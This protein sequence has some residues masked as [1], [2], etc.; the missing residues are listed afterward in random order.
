M[1]YRSPSGG[2]DLPFMRFVVHRAIFGYSISS[3]GRFSF[4]KFLIESTLASDSSTSTNGTS[5]EGGKTAGSDPE[6]DPL[7]H[8]SPNLADLSIIREKEADKE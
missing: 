3:L 1:L 6:T 7:F 5:P 2:K 4:R 8:T